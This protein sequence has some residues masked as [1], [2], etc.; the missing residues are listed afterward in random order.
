M[1]YSLDTTAAREGDTQNLRITE[2]GA[3]IGAFTKAEKVTSKKGTTGVEFSFLS[4]EKQSADFLTLWTVNEAGE[5]IYGFKQLMALMTC[6][7]VKDVSE[8]KGTVEKFEDGQKVKVAATI[9]PEL[10]GK[11]IGILLQREEYEKNN[12]QI[13]H[14]FNLVGFFDPQTRMT[15]TEILDKAGTAEKLDKMVAALKDKP[16]QKRA[17]MNHGTPAGEP[18][19]TGDMPDDEIPW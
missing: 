18:A 4:R 14:K 17:A 5:Q 19:P 11:P 12:G 6:M 16:L 13:G 8:T 2:T 1:S 15:A 3:Y 9:H 7:R 10:T